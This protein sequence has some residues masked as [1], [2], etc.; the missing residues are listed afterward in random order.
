MDLQPTIDLIEHP[1]GILSLLDEKCWLPKSTDKCYVEK[2]L[3]E[4]SQSKYLKPDFNS[5]ADFTLV[6]YAGSMSVSSHLPNPPFLVTFPSLSCLPPFPSRYLYPILSFLPTLLSFPLFPSLLFCLPP[7]SLPPPPFFLPLTY[8]PSFTSFL[9]LPI[10]FIC[11]FLA[12]YT[13]S[14]SHILTSSA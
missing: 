7:L 9:I 4:H 3:H 13:T 14:H 6:H 1:M 11:I 5:K 12:E 2:L 8:T 10:S